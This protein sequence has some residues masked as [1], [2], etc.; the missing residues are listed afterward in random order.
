MGMSGEA[1]ELHVRIAVCQEESDELLIILADRSYQGIYKRWNDR[2]LKVWTFILK[3]FD[4]IV[5]Y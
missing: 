2:C 1:G 4:V 3:Y 5:T